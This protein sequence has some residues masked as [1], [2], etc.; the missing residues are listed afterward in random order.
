MRGAGVAPL[1]AVALVFLARRADPAFRT[2]S[3][4]AV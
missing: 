3:P 1:L 2:V 4:A